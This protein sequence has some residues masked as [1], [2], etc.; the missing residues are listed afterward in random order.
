[1][2]TLPWTGPDRFESDSALVMASRFRLTRFRDV[3][4]FLLDA[5]RVHRQI[6]RADGVLGVSLVAHPLRR[7]FWTLSAW[8]DREALMV[9]VGQEPH[10][11][12]MTRY[13]AKMAD[14]TFD[15]WPVAASELPISWSTAR[16]RIVARAQASA[17]SNPQQTKAG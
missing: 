7:E 17:L 16:R 3:G 11:T 6:R 15:F 2:P 10:R 13:R 14:S 8:R 9:A 5:L 4:P 12:V 1:M